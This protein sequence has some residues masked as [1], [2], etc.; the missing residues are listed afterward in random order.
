[1]GEGV[2][3]AFLLPLCIYVCHWREGQSGAMVTSCARAA[4]GVALLSGL[5]LAVHLLYLSHWAVLHVPT[6]RITSQL[7]ERDLKDGGKDKSVEGDPEG[8]MGEG[9]KP[10]EMER[11]DTSPKCDGII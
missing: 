5:R 10:K 4:D 3:L 6:F 7:T 2:W 1:M 11:L 9:V 8:E